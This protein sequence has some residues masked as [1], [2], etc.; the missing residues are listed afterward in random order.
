M[1][2]LL[3]ALLLVSSTPAWALPEATLPVAYFSVV[4]PWLT[5]RERGGTFDG[6]GGVPIRYRTYRATGFSRGTIV[7]SPGRGESMAK[8]D[9]LV[10]DWLRAGGFDIYLMDHRGQGFS[11]R[12]LE[13]TQVGHVDSFDNY[14]KDFREFMTDI[15]IPQARG[16]RFLLAHSMG[17]AIAAEYLRQYPDDFTAVALSAPMFEINTAPYPETVALSLAKVMIGLGKG[18]EYAFGQKPFNPESS[19]EENPLTSS[20]IRWELNQSFSRDLHPETALGGVSFR[21]VSESI[22]ATRRVR[23]KASELKMPMILFQSGQDRVVKPV[24]QTDVCSKAAQCRLIQT[25]SAQHEVLMERDELRGQAMT[26]IL[27]FFKSHL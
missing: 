27:D 13:D 6:E 21:W 22:Q 17:G 24:G 10:F 15:V 26:E 18:S 11:G 20:R 19:F 7:V 25:A 1:T 8:Y 16:K 5:L 2:K 9:E 12:M 3:V 23:Q 4:R 14:V